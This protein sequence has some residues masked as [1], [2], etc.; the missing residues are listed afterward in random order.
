MFYIVLHSIVESYVARS[1]ET[2]YFS[3][4]DG[5]GDGGA[6]E[7]EAED[8]QGLFVLNVQDCICISVYLK[9]HK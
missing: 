6:S 7:P 8:L 1:G 9:M 3:G 2:K 5:G 4:G